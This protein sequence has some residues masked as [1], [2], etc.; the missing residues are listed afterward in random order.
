MHPWGQVYSFH[1]H[2]RLPSSDIAPLGIVKGVDL[3][4]VFARFHGLATG[5]L[6]T[7]GLKITVRST[8]MKIWKGISIG[9]MAL[10][11]STQVLAADVVKLGFFDM[12]LIIDRSEP[13]KMGL[14]KFNLEKEKIRQ[15][16]AAQLQELQELD[17]EFKKKEHMLS[18]EV[19]KA[20]AQELIVKKN[21]Y[22]RATYE[23][24]QKLGGLEQ[25][26]LNPL[27]N[28]VFDI[29]ARIGKE[30]GY[31]MIWEMR[32]T[33]LAYAP[34]SLELTD[35]IIQELNEVAAKQDK[36]SSQ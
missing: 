5:I 4:P 3:I 22:D 15:G 31:T 33:G 34:E 1:K 16:L 13:G 17:A 36:S 29:V 6:E 27:K 18:L 25:E 2:R 30:E 32:Q 8:D 20:K 19:K 23:A 14:E 26:L 35:R 9:F 28:M 11:F 7:P 21:E 12:Q 24:N 10:L